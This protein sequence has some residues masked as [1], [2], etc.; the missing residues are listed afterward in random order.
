L[1]EAAVVGFAALAAGCGAESPAAATLSRTL[2]I[3]SGE[4]GQPVAGAAVT[5][6]G[7]T[8]RA[9]DAGRVPLPAGAAAAVDVVAE[10]F[11]S[12]QTRLG[13]ERLTLWPIGP[14][15]DAEYV[16][17]IIYRSSE[18][19][20]S[21]LAGPEQPL[22]RL[23]SGRAVL[24]P[25]REIARDAEAV[26]A[27]REAA[28]ILNGATGAATF[29]V[30][31]SGGGATVIAL[32]LDPSLRWIAAA[33]RD[34]AGGAIVGA[35]IAFGSLANAR[36]VKIVAHELGHVLGLQ[37]SASR[38]DLMYFEAREDGPSTF[39]AAERLT[40]RLLLQRVPGNRYP[41][42]DRDAN[43]GIASTSVAFD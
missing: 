9:D 38:A 18:A 40:I 6:G 17:A 30:G 12:R 4:T 20:R 36:R 43:P 10:G 5:I 8:W 37:H 21:A 16:R 42:N 3:V 22:Q 28:A 7:V 29:Q 32:D 19:G 1:A 23:A 33:Y 27:L 24:V 2:T 11:L 26:A 35:R 13:P 15:H 31:G 25:S 39:T 14:G 34:V 41:D